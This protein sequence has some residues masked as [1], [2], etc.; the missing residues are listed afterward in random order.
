MLVQQTNVL[1][2]LIANVTG[3]Y[4][5]GESLQRHVLRLDEGQVARTFALTATLLLGKEIL[6]YRICRIVV[7]IVLVVLLAIPVNFFCTLA[8]QFTRYLIPAKVGFTLGA[9]ALTVG[10]REGILR[11]HGQT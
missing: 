5:L 3:V 8:R 10:R 6:Q 9:S 4:G 7:A 11:S 1:E 2:L